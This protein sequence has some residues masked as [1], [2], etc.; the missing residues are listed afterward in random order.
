VSAGYIVVV[1]PLL[2][3]VP[4]SRNDRGWPNHV[5]LSGVSA[6]SGSFAVT[7][8]PRTIS[9]ERLGDVIGQVDDGCLAEIKRWLGDFLDL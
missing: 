7:E 8:Q 4:A 1:T 9:R 5:A 3:V 2:I 6:L